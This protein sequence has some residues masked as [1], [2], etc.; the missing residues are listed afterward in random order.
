M[1]DE[2]TG[3]NEHEH[4]GDGDPHVWLDVAHA[5]TMVTDIRDALIAVDP[6]GRDV[7]T[8]NAASYATQLDDLDGWIRDQIA[9]IP[10]EDRKL[11]TNHDAFGYYVRA[12]GLT[13]VGSIIPGLDSQS[14][15]SAKQT[16]ALIDRI[17][18]EHVKAIFTEASLNPNLTKRIAE[19]AGVNVVDNLYADSL[20]PAGSGADTYIGMMRTDT[21]LIVEAL[22]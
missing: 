16:A 9:T 19:D 7:Y 22:R 5:K 20:G 6:G 4:E 15:P 21:T 8:Q 11:V 3:D 17:R 2:A 10:A 14:Q 12:Y 13:L 1:D 18:A